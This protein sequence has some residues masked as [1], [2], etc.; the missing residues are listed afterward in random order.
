MRKAPRIKTDRSIKASAT[1]KSLTRTICVWRH[2][3]WTK[4]FWIFRFILHKVLP[5]T[6]RPAPNRRM[7]EEHQEGHYCWK[8]AGAQGPCQCYVRYCRFYR[9][10]Q[11]LPNGLWENNKLAIGFINFGSNCADQFL[12]ASNSTHINNKRV[13]PHW[14]SNRI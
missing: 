7:G 3:E 6:W 10:R 14:C 4:R 11:S 9:R 8:A 1:V 12:K 13:D 5:G 2:S